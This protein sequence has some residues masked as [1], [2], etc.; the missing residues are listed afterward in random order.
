MRRPLKKQ[1]VICLSALLRN[2]SINLQRRKRVKFKHFAKHWL[3]CAHS[4]RFR[5]C[6]KHPDCRKRPSGVSLPILEDHCRYDLMQFNSS[7]RPSDTWFR[8][9]YKPKQNDLSCILDKLRPLASTSSYVASA[10]PQL[11]LE[12]GKSRRTRRTRLNKYGAS[13]R[14]PS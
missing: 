11:M 8:E 7:T 5:S 2:F 1:F 14:Q 4:C 9:T 3:H 12:A 10:L 6:L 13:N